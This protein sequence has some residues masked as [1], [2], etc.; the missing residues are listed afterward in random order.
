MIRAPCPSVDSNALE[1]TFQTLE[2]YATHIERSF[3]LL[4]EPGVK[5]RI[6]IVVFDTLPLTRFTIAIMNGKASLG[7][8]GGGR[9]KRA[10]HTAFD[11]EGR[12]LSGDAA[13]D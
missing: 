13:G 2:T 12:H 3:E 4:L 1:L 9:L 11:C 5:V 10:L 7:Y 8:R 6:G